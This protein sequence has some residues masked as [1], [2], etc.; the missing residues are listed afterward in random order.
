MKKLLVLIVAVLV[1]GLTGGLMAADGGA[2]ATGEPV[3]GTVPFIA[4]WTFTAT[5]QESNLADVTYAML[6]TGYIDKLDIQVCTDMDSNDTLSIAAKIG[7][8][9]LPSVTGSVYPPKGKKNSVTADSDFLIQIDAAGHTDSLEVQNSFGSYKLLTS[10][11]QTILAS[12]TKYPNGIE[13]QTFKI[14]NRIMLDTQT[15]MP[16][17]YSITMTLTLSQE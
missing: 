14:D 16:G 6:E 13:N 15:D 8:W 9:T 11:D 5:S 2:T 4:N 12:K 1:L 7:S 10:N 17:A 3:G